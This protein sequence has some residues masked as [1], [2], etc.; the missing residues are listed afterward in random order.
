M[1]I[2]KGFQWGF[3]I[4]LGVFIA[5]AI[6]IFV[7][8]IVSGVG[9]G[10]LFSNFHKSS[11]EQGFKTSSISSNVDNLSRLSKSRRNAAK[12]YLSLFE[13]ALDSYKLDVQTYPTTKQGLIALR[14]KP[15]GVTAWDGPY[16]PKA[17][18]LD[19]W[20]NPFFYERLNETE[21]RIISFGADGKEG[22]SNA[23]LDIILQ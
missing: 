7:F 14:T 11:F 21:F 17:I 22:G 10:F 20:G 12:A 9:I 16:L 15:S 8:I 23:N 5:T 13:T 1:Y 6:A 3:G 4:A 19:P 2:W 18:S